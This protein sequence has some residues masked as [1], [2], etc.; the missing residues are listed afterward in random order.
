[1]RGLDRIIW[2]FSFHPADDVTAAKHQE[3]RDACKELALLL[4]YSLPFGRER[5][6]ALTKV[7]E[8]MFWSNAAIAREGGPS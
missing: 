6:L 8:S 3:V 7:E 1:M 5:S 4:D 2:D